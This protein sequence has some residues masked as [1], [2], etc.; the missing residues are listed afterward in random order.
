MNLAVK[1]TTT[2]RLRAKLQRHLPLRVVF[3]NDNGF[4]YGAGLALLRQVQSFLVMGH[5]V[6]SIS[7]AQGLVESGIPLKPRGATGTWLGSF[8]LPHLTHDRG[9]PMETTVQVLLA[10]TRRFDPDLVITGNLHGSGWTFDL[11]VALRQSGIPTVAFM[12][13]CQMISGR[14]AYPGTCT[15]Y[16]VGCDHNCPTWEEYP[17]LEP[18]LIYDAWRVRRQAVEGPGSVAIAANSQWTLS[19]AKQA[20]SQISYADCLYYG[21]DERLF[22][23]IDKAIARKLLG[24]PEDRFVV[25]TGAVNMREYRKGGHIF[26]ELID[27]LQH[28]TELV[29]FGKA[30]NLQNVRGT[31]FLR[32]YRKM[33]LLYSA[34]DVFVGTSLE[35]AFGQTFCEASACELPI[36]AFKIGGVPEIA[37]HG[38]NAR[39]AADTT[40]SAMIEEI[41]FFRANP[42][43]R[44]TYGAKGRAIVEAEFTLKCQGDRWMKYLNTW[45]EQLPLE[46]C[47]HF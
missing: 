34:A 5:E 47:N 40:A 42:N 13:D 7:W 2:D 27:R 14:C 6:A 1:S 30:D 15:Q 24:I 23:K 29:V 41:E 9:I 19:M 33:P 12:H 35:E 16:K 21:L 8:P 4:Q 44:I 31:E 18:E 28:N 10:E 3:I 32:D 39:L 17:K 26:A 36:V 46:A 25:L 20:F 22:S 11:L 38:Q 37:R 45:V 43:Q